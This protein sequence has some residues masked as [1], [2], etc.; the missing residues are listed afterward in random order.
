MQFDV[1]LFNRLKLTI[2]ATPSSEP[3]ALQKF[4]MPASS[5]LLP[6]RHYCLHEGSFFE[7]QHVLNFFPQPSEKVGALQAGVYI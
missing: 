7:S 4:S 1:S 5:P 6:A 2:P 3:A